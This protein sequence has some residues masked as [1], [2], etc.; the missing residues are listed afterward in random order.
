MYIFLFNVYCG[1]ENETM[2]RRVT[3][4]S[5]ENIFLK[6][7]EKNPYISS[8]RD[9]CRFLKKTDRRRV[10]PTRRGEDTETHVGPPGR[11]FSW[12]YRFR[13]CRPR[14]VACALTTPRL[15]VSYLRRCIQPR[16]VACSLMALC[17]FA[18]Y[19]V[20]AKKPRTLVCS[21][22]AAV[23]SMAARSRSRCRSRFSRRNTRLVPS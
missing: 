16:A 11:T 23:F 7:R 20:R 17:L 8:A 1:Y 14:N 18:V 5:R 10:S 3:R 4:N 9:T 15:S 2:S 13:C 19:R 21:V 22:M 6:I 12:L